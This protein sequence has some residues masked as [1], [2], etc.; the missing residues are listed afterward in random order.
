MNKVQ[1]FELP[2]DEMG[3]AKKFYSTVFKWEFQDY[4]MPGMEYSG[5]YT[6][7]VDPKTHRPKEVGAING[8]LLKRGGPWLLNTPTV[9][10]VVEDIKRAIKKI[11]A[12]GGSV[13]ME[14][15][16]VGDMGLYAYFKDTEGNMIGLW[17][18]LKKP[19]AKATKKKRK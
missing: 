15:A 11:T 6:T 10:V 19:A 9:A 1:H 14:P 18:D 7:E 8:G 17:Q 3:R 16:R 5:I 13:S 4:P 2:A 12:A